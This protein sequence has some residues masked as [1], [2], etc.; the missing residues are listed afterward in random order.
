MLNKNVLDRLRRQYPV[1]CRVKLIQMDNAQAPPVGTKGT[2]TGI[3]DTGSILV[4]WDTGFGLNVLYG[5]DIIRKAGDS[6]DR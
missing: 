4:L 5:I 2:I 6:D 3:D 1:G